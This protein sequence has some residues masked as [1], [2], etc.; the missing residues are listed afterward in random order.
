M[1]I[2]FRCESCSQAIEVDDDGAGQWVACPFCSQTSLAPASSDPNIQFDVPVAPPQGGPGPEVVGFDAAPF[3]AA[4]P[5]RCVL[6]WIALACLGACFLCM[7]VLMSIV[8]PAMANLGPNPDPVAIQKAV[9]AKQMESPLAIVAG[10]LSSLTPIAGLALAIVSLVRRES[11][12]WPAIVAISLSAV[13]VL[14]MCLGLMV[15][16]MA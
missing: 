10:F 9:M 3:V 2:Q 16:V 6:G 7:C 15:Q 4:E 8:L 1:P 13:M 5:R 14:L 12:R 11:P